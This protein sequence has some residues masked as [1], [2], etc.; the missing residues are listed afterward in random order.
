MAMR[1]YFI[2][3]AFGMI[4]ASGKFGTYRFRIL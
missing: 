4:E 2:V 3:K 1:L